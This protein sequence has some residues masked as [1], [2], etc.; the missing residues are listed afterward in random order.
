MNVKEHVLSKQ[1]MPFP[2]LVRSGLAWQYGD[3]KRRGM[4]KCA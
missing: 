3:V 2:G 4:S 1:H